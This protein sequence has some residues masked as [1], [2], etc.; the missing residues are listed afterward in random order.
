MITYFT[1]AAAKLLT[2]KRAENAKYY[3]SDGAFALDYVSKLANKGLV[4][5][6]HYSA[7]FPKMRR[8][9]KPGEEKW[10]LDFENSKSLYEA[11]VIDAHLPFSVLSDKRFVI[12]MTHVVYWEHVVNR[13]PVAECTTDKKKEERIGTRYLMIREPLSRNE[14]LRSIWVPFATY[15]PERP[16]DPYHLTYIAKKYNNTVDR[17]LDRQF[18]Y[19]RRILRCILLTIEKCDDFQK[20]NGSNK[21]SRQFGVVINNMLGINYLTTLSDEEIISAISEIIR[22]LMKE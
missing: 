15:D 19:D 10:Q 6:D 7:E 2:D 4:E 14:F 8:V 17:I 20:I 18:S 22:L 1:S 16:D 3:E 12:Y 5:N 21:A 9:L 13:W 11:L